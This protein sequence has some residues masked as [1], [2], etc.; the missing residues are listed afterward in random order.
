MRRI[1][2]YTLS[3]GIWLCGS[4][5]CLRRRPFLSRGSSWPF[6]GWRYWGGGCFLGALWGSLGVMWIT[7]R[8]LMRRWRNRVP[9]SKKAKVAISR[10]TLAGAQE[11]N[12]H[13]KKIKRKPSMI[14]SDWCYYVKNINYCP[15]CWCSICCLGSASCCFSAC[16]PY[17]SAWPGGYF[18]LL[19]AFWAWLY[20]P[21][22]FSLRYL[23][24]FYAICM[25]IWEVH[26]DYHS[27]H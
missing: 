4:P 22:C 10:M 27:F 3:I 12:W 14:L 1:N 24:F 6:W 16:R 5:L 26:Q 23:W 21:L 7:T 19:L 2:V 25:I 20:P 18:C 11:K 13:R 9:L 15:C 8:C 17:H